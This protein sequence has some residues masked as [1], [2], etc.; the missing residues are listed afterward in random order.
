MLKWHRKVHF[1]EIFHLP[2]ASSSLDPRLTALAG[3]WFLQSGIQEAHGGVARYHHSD[4]GRNARVSTEITG[5]TVSALVFLYERSGDRELL[6][7]AIRA[8]RFLLDVAWSP[9]L[10][11]FL[12]STRQTAT[13]RRH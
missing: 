10:R 3:Q 11:R 6:D 4:T 12:S 9:S 2:Q 1:Q 5:Y 13:R 8:G 7:A